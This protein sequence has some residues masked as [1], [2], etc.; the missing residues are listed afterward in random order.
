MTPAR[1]TQDSFAEALGNFTADRV[2]NR[3]GRVKK[4][5]DTA[6]FKG[7]PAD[8]IHDAWEALLEVQEILAAGLCILVEQNENGGGRGGPKRMPKNFVEWLWMSTERAPLATA[9]IFLGIVALKIHGLN[10]GDL[11]K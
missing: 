8:G 1:N 6:S 4:I 9:L 7:C 5:I 10:L 3:L 2:K 11:L